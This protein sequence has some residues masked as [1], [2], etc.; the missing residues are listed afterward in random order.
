M[1]YSSE[2]R[3]PQT[4]VV[5]C[6]GSTLGYNTVSSFG[7]QVIGFDPQRRKISFGNPNSTATIFVYQLIDLNGNTLTPHF[8]YP[9]IGGAW[10]ILAGTTFTFTGDCQGPWGA[11]AITGSTN[12]ISIMSSR[13]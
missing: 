12:A 13:S 6:S 8:S 11:L 10:P 4:Y 2:A 9:G 7:A 5:P 1:A 3:A